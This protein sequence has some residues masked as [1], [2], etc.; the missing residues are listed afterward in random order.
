MQFLQRLLPPVLAIAAVAVLLSTFFSDHKSDYG[1]VTMPAGGVVELPKGTSTLYVGDITIPVGG[2]FEQVS[3][4]SVFT[5]TPVGGGEPAVLT[6]PGGED[7]S[8]ARSSEALA[9]RGAVADVEV[10]VA[11]DYQVSGGIGNLASVE[12][13]FGRSSF[14]AVLDSWMLWGGL[15]LAAIAI[16][17]LPKPRHRPTGEGWSRPEMDQGAS[18]GGGAGEPASS[19]APAAQPFSPYNG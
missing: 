5:I 6:P 3:G 7:T 12:F 2:D 8:L 9:N 17:L 10:P 18:G 16:A 14:A 4:G 1:A 19:G 13:T 11:G 15:L